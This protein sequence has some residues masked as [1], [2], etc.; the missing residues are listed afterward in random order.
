M[1]HTGLQGWQFRSQAFHNAEQIKRIISLMAFSVIIYKPVGTLLLFSLSSL[2]MCI[3]AA[4]CSTAKGT[5]CLIPKDPY[6]NME[7]QEYVEL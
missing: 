5:V 4:T 2:Y 6:G 1:Q 7:L 3:W